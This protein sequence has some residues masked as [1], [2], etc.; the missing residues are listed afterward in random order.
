MNMKKIK[1]FLNNLF[2][3]LLSEMLVATFIFLLVFVLVSIG[4]FIFTGN[5]IKAI[6]AGFTVALMVLLFIYS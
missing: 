1:L 3:T 4:I 2:A 6:T 5:I